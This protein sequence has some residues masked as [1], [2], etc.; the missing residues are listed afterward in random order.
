MNCSKCNVELKPDS[1]ACPSC[2]ATVDAS[3]FVATAKINATPSGA[4]KIGLGDAVIALGAFIFGVTGL[5]YL[6][7]YIDAKGDFS[8]GLLAI[9]ALMLSPAAPLLI[10]ILSLKNPG[11]L[12]LNYFFAGF[13]WLMK[14]TSVSIMEVNYLTKFITAVD[15]WL[16]FGATLI[17]A[18]SCAVQCK[19]GKCP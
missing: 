1:N 8:M 4:R 15:F 5:M 6:I 11:L 12:R 14:L 17:A 18:G 7:G 16:V 3:A 2:G 19:S 9:I 13:I 10:T